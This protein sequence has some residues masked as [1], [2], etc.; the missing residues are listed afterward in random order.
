[1]YFIKDTRLLLIAKDTKLKENKAVKL[2]NMTSI[3]FRT[4]EPFFFKDDC[5]WAQGIFLG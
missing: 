5:K 2:V 3:S 1:M 4:I